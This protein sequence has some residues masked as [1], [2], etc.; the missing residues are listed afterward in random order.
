MKISLTTGSAFHYDVGLISGLLK[1]NLAIDVIGGDTLQRYAGM[2][3]PGVNFKNLYGAERPG[4]PRWLKAFQVV[5]V[6]LKIMGYAGRADSPIIHIQWPYKFILFDRT[7]LNIYYKA[8]GKKLV[9]TAHNVDGDARDGISS[10]SRHA[11]LRFSYRMMDHIIVHTN[12]MKSELMNDF[13]ILDDKITVIPHGVM[14]AVPETAL[15]KA[16]ARKKLGLDA[17]QRILLFF[18]M[19]SPYKGL[20]FLVEAMADLRSR[21]KTFTLVIAG[22][23]KECPEYW[24]KLRQLI[25]GTGLK[26]YVITDLR[27]IPDEFVE[28][29]LKAADVMVLPYR[30][31]FQSGA[32]FLAYRFGLP[33]VATDVGSFREDIIEGQTGF[34]CRADDSRDMACAIETYFSSDLFANLEVRSRDIR[35]YANERYSWEHIGELTRHVYE[36]VLQQ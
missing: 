16:E 3:Q 35:D 7:L 13:G 6:Y 23:I 20:E 33:V 11:S 8:L 22:R 1:Q 21:G 17:N 25:D 4:G 15:N 29:Y 14:S 31:I 30:S 28:V 26:D 32:L 27:R 5:R 36:R 10:W 2:R 34:L 18:G 12:R 19:I 9:F 24:D